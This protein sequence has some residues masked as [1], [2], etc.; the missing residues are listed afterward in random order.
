M[1]PAPTVV[2]EAPALLQTLAAELIAEAELGAR[3]HA[4]LGFQLDASTPIPPNLCRIVSFSTGGYHT[5]EKDFVAFGQTDDEVLLVQATWRGDFVWSIRG[6]R[7]DVVGQARRIHPAEA[8]DR[9]AQAPPGERVGSRGLHRPADARQSGRPALG[10]FDSRI[11]HR[12]ILDDRSTLDIDVA[13]RQNAV[14]AVDADR[15]VA[16]RIPQPAGL[17]RS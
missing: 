15:Q 6:G 17:R 13:E 5:E 2:N 1:L 9:R 12:P 3:V 7:A 4:A 11:E 8:E 16:V 10:S 14:L